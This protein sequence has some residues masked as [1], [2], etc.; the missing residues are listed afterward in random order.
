MR[1]PNQG[2]FTNSFGVLDANRRASLVLKVPLDLY[3]GYSGLN[4]D[5]AFVEYGPQGFEHVSNAVSLR[6]GERR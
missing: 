4:L 3:A 6:F 2:L 5:H 1:Q